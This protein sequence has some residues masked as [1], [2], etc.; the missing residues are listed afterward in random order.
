MIAAGLAPD[1]AE[2]TMRAGSSVK[3][4]FEDARKMLKLLDLLE[5]LDD[6]QNV[7]SNA[8]FSEVAA[9]LEASPD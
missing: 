3:L 7:Y 4:G 5:D 2:V 9:Q 1:E 8:D 6:T